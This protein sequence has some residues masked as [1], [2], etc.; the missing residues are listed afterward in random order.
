MLHAQRFRAAR[1]AAEAGLRANPTGFPID[2]QVHFPDPTSAFVSYLKIAAIGGFVLALPVVFY[3]LWAFIA[4]GLYDREK[5]LIA[6]F[7]F[8]ST[9]F[10][11]GGALFGYHFVFPVGYE[12]FLGFGGMVA[13]TQVKVVPTIMM[14][15]YLGFTS[16]MLLAFGVVFQLPLFVFFLSLAGIVTWQ[17]L[18][19]FGRYFTVIAFVV[20]AVLT[21]TPDVYSQVMLALP[22]VGLYFV[23]VGLAFLFAPKKKPDAKE[24]AKEDAKPDALPEKVAAA[25]KAAAAK[26]SPAGAD[27]VRAAKIKKWEAEQEKLR[28]AKIQAAQDKGARAAAR[29]RAD[30]PPPPRAGDPMARDDAATR[31]LRRT[32]T[33][34][35]YAL[36]FAA[37][38]GLSPVALAA[39]LLAD[40][41]SG[42]R[43]ALARAYLMTLVYLAYELVGV[44]VAAALWLRGGGEA[45]FLDGN[46]RLQWWWAG[47]LFDATRALFGLR[48][49]VTGAAEVAPGPVLVFARH[50]S[51]ADTLL[52]AALLSRPHG[53]RLRYVLKR[54]LLWDPCLDIVGHRLPNAFVRRGSRDTAGDVA[55]V[56]GPRRGPRPARRR[57]HLPRGDAR[58]AGPP[59]ARP[60][61]HRGRARRH[62]RADRAGARARPPPAAAPRGRPRAAGGRAR[63]RRGLPRARGLRRRP[64]ARRPAPRR[65]GRAH[66]RVHLWRR[67]RAEVPADREGRERWLAAQWQAMD[68]WVGQL[69]SREGTKVSPRT[70]AAR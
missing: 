51:V 21:P 60:R 2:P 45:R 1:A 13:G 27:D 56:R 61:A 35:A 23:A 65:A 53:A 37:L 44:A 20:A 68:D 14:D 66:V 7:V 30:A 24:D 28:A 62:A 18:L 22:L 16:Q 48:V 9:L 57:A 5:K 36:A 55:A 26:D 70:R 54:E 11:L 41:A 47:G 33:V 46:Y 50:V 34:G 25:K 4:P 42:S 64:H 40:L 10:F 12:W 59:P 17:Q 43:L 15:E 49:E 67:P 29:P 69:A 6:P 58:D 19:K 32:L 38:A 31:L 8:F 39:A 3:Q 52:A 63:G